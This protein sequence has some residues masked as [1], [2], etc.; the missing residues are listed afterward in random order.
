M[1]CKV[2]LRSSNSVIVT[3]EVSEP[4]LWRDAQTARAE[5]NARVENANPGRGWIDSRK[6]PRKCSGPAV[7]KR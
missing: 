2:F 1:F 4:E 6:N 3:I 7:S 5:Q